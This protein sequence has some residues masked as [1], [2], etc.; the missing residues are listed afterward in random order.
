VFA[1]ILAPPLVALSADIKG[2]LKPGGV[3][4][5]SGLLR[6]QER[7]VLAA[8]TSK[9]FRLVRRIHRDAWATLV[10]RRPRNLRRRPTFSARHDRRN[11]MPNMNARP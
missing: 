4:I 8:Y 7:R 2:A 1:N 9:G 5:L 6:T 10:L 3:A 11:G